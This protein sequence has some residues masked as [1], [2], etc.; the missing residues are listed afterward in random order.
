[1]IVTD[2]D[3][4]LWTQQSWL[5]QASHWIKHELHQ[6]GIKC[7][8]P[9]QQLRVRHWSTVFQIPTNSGNIYFKAVTPELAHEAELTQRLSHQHPHCTPEVLAIDGK[10]GWL[11]MAEGGMTLRETLKTEEDIQ[12]WENLLRIYTKLQ[13]DSIKSVNEFLEMG[14]PD[15]RLATLPAKFQQLL[16]DAEI[17]GLD[18]PGGL[19]LLERQCLQN[20]VDILDKICRQLETVGIPETL[21]HGDLHDGNVFFCDERYMFFDW[22]DSSITHPFFSLHSTYDCLKRRFELGTDSVWFKRLRR[23]YLEE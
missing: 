9:I 5:A 8:G 17:L 15:R 1:M 14:V 19:N 20:K 10:R 21:H 2:S 12:Y 6:K 13:Q 7:I 22:G 16:T 3:G 11:L 18:H 4:L 23:F